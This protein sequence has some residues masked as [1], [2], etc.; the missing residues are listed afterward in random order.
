M[1]NLDNITFGEQSFERENVIII[2]ICI[3]LY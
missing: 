2:S 3:P 1:N